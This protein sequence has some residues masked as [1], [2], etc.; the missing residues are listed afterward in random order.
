MLVLHPIL[1]ILLRGGMNTP[2]DLNKLVAE[3]RET[4]GNAQNGN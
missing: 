4:K 3:Q 1:E 2:A